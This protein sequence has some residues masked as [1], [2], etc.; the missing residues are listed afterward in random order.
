VKD[1]TVTKLA[2]ANMGDFGVI[3]VIDTSQS[4]AGT[5][6]R[7]A[8][9]AARTL[10]A[11][12]AGA[13]ELGAIEF[14]RSASVV[15]PL[16]TDAA[17]I[18]AALSREPPLSFGTHIYDATLLAI[19]G[20][21]NSGVAAASVIVLS[22]GADVG[23]TITEK[24]VAAAAAA[25]HVRVYTVGV[26]DHYFK[27]Q[28]LASL[29]RATS[30]S[31]TVSSAAR[32]RQVFTTI[33][34]QLSARYVIRYRSL[35]GAGRHVQV[36]LSVRGV[37]GAWVGGYVS[38]LPPGPPVSSK[39]PTSPHATTSFWTSTVAVVLVAFGAALFFVGGLLVHLVPRSRKEDLRQR[40]GEFTHPEEPEVSE[41]TDSRGLL[42]DGVDRWMSRFDRW[43]RFRDE[44]DLGGFKRSAAEIV[45][46]MLAGTVIVAVLASVAIGTPLI[47][48][49]LFLIGPFVTSSIVR[50]RADR[51]RRLFSD[52][53]AGHLEEIGSAMRAGHSISASISAMADDALDPSRREFQSAMAD[54]QLGV[55]LDV[56][57]RPIAQRMRCSDIEQLALVAALNQRTG[58]NMAAVL[59]LIAAGVRERAD[60]R[61]ELDALTAQARLSRWIVSGL[62]FGILG[63][64]ALVRPAYIGPLFH[65]T[66]G[67]IALC[68][69]IGLVLLGS[70]VMRL[71]VSAEA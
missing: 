4:M 5:P 14:N 24:V 10:A 49:P 45:L 11:Q 50:H 60:L 26:H 55:P 61:R 59:D 8:L 35:Q 22:D 33:E 38:P 3:L 29:A 56:A 27:P 2:T 31:Y 6:I 1:V 9:V 43:P 23:S 30:G 17:T 21:H 39:R 51:Q 70:F 67:V 12:R 57:L 15:L 58:G 20:L 64:L 13:Q 41:T 32:L 65:T 53:L 18:S 48:L 34:S 63:L 71:I 47:S 46:I 68:L 40:I 36:R 62:P 54:E 66:G 25:D 52:Q 28:T 7:E 37:P 16:T 69:A 42:G 19:Q 44:V